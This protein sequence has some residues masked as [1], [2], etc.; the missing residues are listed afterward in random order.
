MRPRPA[1]PG[2]AKKGHLKWGDVFHLLLGGIKNRVRKLFF[3]GLLCSDHDDGGENDCFSHGSS[4]CLINRLVLQILTN[5]YRYLRF[6]EGASD[7]SYTT[8]KLFVLFI[9]FVASIIFQAVL[10]LEYRTHQDQEDIQ[11]TV[12]T[13]NETI[14]RSS[15]QQ[16]TSPCVS[17]LQ[18]ILKP[19]KLISTL[20]KTQK[21]TLQGIRMVSMSGGVDVPLYQ[22]KQPRQLS[23]QEIPFQLVLLS[24]M[25]DTPHQINVV[26]DMAV[27]SDSWFPGYFWSVV[28]ICDC[29]ALEY[30]HVGWKFTSLTDPSSTSSSSSDSFYALTV[31]SI[32]TVTKKEVATAAEAVRVFGMAAPGWMLANLKEAN[33]NMTTLTP[34]RQ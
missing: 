1:C 10:G 2:I 14:K 17:N 22:F 3:S 31:H 16:C 15:K 33:K 7:E 4:F 13:F 27:A 18:S 5:S 21:D 20:Y 11:V 12:N 28:V 25:D 6:Q 23:N 8:M 29:S 32:N 9:L 30:R 19:E 24:E 26:L 34:Q